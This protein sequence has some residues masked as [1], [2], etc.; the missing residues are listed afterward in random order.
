MTFYLII[1]KDIFTEYISV[2]NRFQGS[3]EKIFYNI[4]CFRKHM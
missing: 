2:L 1:L 3:N 4:P